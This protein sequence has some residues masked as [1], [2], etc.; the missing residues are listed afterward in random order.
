MTYTYEE[1]GALYAESYRI[2]IKQGDQFLSP[3]HDI[4]LHP[5]PSNPAVVNMVVEV[6]RWTNAKMEISKELKLNPI[7]QDIK[8]GKMR[9]IA[10]LFPNKGYPWNYGAF[11]QTW[12]DPKNVDKH[13]GYCGDNDPLDVCEISDIISPPGSIVQVKILG[14]LAMIDEGETDWKVIAINTADPA[15]SE[16]SN[17][18]DVERLKPGL[19]RR[20]VEWF[21]YYKVPDGKPANQFAFNEE[22]RDQSFAVEIVKHTHLSWQQLIKKEVDNA[23]ISLVNTTVESSSDKV[24]KS[25]AQAVVD[26][27]PGLTAAVELPN[28]I[29]NQF[30]ISAWSI[31]W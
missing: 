1:R 27:N 7:K 9:F 6:N 24:D 19:L 21:K 13:T 18:N 30:Y 22:F 5:D 3:F 4:P 12:E 28:T 23:G 20:T 8:K 10:N 26:E 11:P 15:I 14:V 2:F 16:Y 17:I 31:I 29:N 25:A